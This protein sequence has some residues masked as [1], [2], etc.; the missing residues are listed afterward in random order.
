METNSAH[1]S[2]SQNLIGESAIT[3]PF[4]TE[5]FVA[6]GVPVVRGN[7]P[8][9]LSMR[10][11]SPDIDQSQMAQAPIQSTAF[12]P[13]FPLE[14]PVAPPLPEESEAEPNNA[15][16]MV[17]TSPV[18]HANRSNQ[19]SRVASEFVW[20][21]EYGL[22]MNASFLN[23]PERLNGLALPYGPA[24]LI[25]YRI[26]FDALETRSGQVVANIQPDSDPRA[27]VWGILYRIPRRLTERRNG[28]L[29]ML[30]RLHLAS[31]FEPRE[32]IVHETYRK[33]NISCITY[34]ASA[35]A[36]QQFRLL[37]K[38]RQGIDN[39]YIQRL[40]ACARQQK[41]PGKYLDELVQ[42]SAANPVQTMPQRDV[43]PGS[44][45][46]RSHN[47]GLAVD[48]QSGEVSLPPEQNT[49]PLPTL[50]GKAG[51][52]LQKNTAQKEAL[53]ISSSRW[54]MAFALYVVLLFLVVLALSVLQ[55]LG[56]WANIFTASFAPLGAPWFV[57]VY[58]LLGGCVSGIITIGRRRST[59]PPVFVVITWFT[60]PFIGAVL[61]ALAYLALS[62]GFFVLV[63][64][65]EQHYAL[66]SLLGALAGFCERWV[67][68]RR[69]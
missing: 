46:S 56:F 20:L 39:A 50:T 54:L 28:E 8:K 17:K 13:D 37:P 3:E 10:G 48:V 32:V 31:H 59:N 29:S 53:P 43:A 38:E 11:Y 5:I 42:F 12:V 66:F 65:N 68:F 45:K 19:S 14:A 51:I 26:V 47:P 63:G 36:R 49:E 41:L 44:P 7:T 62:S 24:V 22:N 4:R 30:D 27:T 61:A 55:A 25:G 21:F 2:Q 6:P 40:L 15:V 35:V 18:S 52:I 64:N 9:P 33:R 34:V 16:G 57:L 58:G 67:F 1:Q 23:S 60:R 69:A